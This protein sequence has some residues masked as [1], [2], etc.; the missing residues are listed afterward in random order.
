MPSSCRRRCAAVVVP[1][2][3]R[4]GVVVVPPSLCR[5]RAVPLWCRRCR[6][7]VVPSSFPSPPRPPQHECWLLW[8]RLSPPPRPP[9]HQCRL[10]WR[11][12]SPPPQGGQRVPVVV[13]SSFPTPA[14][15]SASAGCC[16]PRGHFSTSAGAGLFRKLA[17]MIVS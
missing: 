4:R 9:Q 5:R 13:A 14:G 16:G 10:L 17:D 1:S 15:L 11:R 6:A 12:L 7:V 2:S 3:C 8:R